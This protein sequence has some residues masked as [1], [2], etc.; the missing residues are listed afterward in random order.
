MATN[1]LAS[2][3][4][5]T[6]AA[7]VSGIWEYDVAKNRL[8]ENLGCAELPYYTVDGESYHLGSFD[9]YKLMGVKPQTDS[10]K[11]S[12]CRKLARYLTG[13]ACQTQRFKE[14]SWGPTNTKSSQRD[15]I[16]NHPGLAA[17]NA[18]HKYATQQGQCPGEWF[19]ALK[20]AASGV[21]T[22]STD[23]ELQTILD[24]YYAGLPVLL[25]DE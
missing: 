21:K 3:L 9:G 18:Q 17:L 16:A 6:A 24:N 4:G 20:T 11:A 19:L 5:D 12:V 7:V 23:A 13:E 8:K 14:V 10:K 1:S 22:T 15:E 2:K 25:S